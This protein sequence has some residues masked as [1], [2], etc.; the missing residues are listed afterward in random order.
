MSHEHLP[1][2]FSP[3]S[4][5]LTRVSPDSHRWAHHALVIALACGFGNK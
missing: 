2:V 3:G 4:V 1:M 5:D